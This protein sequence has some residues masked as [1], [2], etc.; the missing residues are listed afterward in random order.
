MQRIYFFNHCQDEACTGMPNGA[1]NYLYGYGFNGKSQTADLFRVAKN[2]TSIMNPSQHQWY[3][4]TNY[5]PSNVGDGTSWTPLGSQTGASVMWGYQ[6]PIY[7]ASIASYPI[8]F[9]V[10]FGRPSY[11]CANNSCSYVMSPYG[12]SAGLAT[13][14]A[15][16]GPFSLSYIPQHDFWHLLPWTAKTIDSNPYHT[17]VISTWDQYT[18]GQSQIVAAVSNSNPAT[19]TVPTL[20]TAPSGQVIALTVTGATGCWA[21]A[22]INA[23]FSMTALST[24]G[25][26]SV[27]GVNTSSCTGSA[28]GA[29][30]A[31]GRAYGASEFWQSVDLTIAPT[32]SG[33]ALLGRSGV[34]FTMAPAENALPR[35]GVQ[36]YFDFWDNV[37]GAPISGPVSAID[38]SHNPPIAALRPCYSDGPYGGCGFYGATYGG[39]WT[40]TGMT[41]ISHYSQSMPM[42]DLTAVQNQF[43]VSALSGDVSWT[44]SGVTS[45]SDVTKRWDMLSLGSGV[46][47]VG[48]SYGLG[49]ASGSFCVN[50]GA[51]SGAVGVCTPGDLISNNAP[52]AWVV[53]KTAGGPISGGGNVR[54]YLNG[55]EVSSYTPW[56]WA[57]PP[58]SANIGSGPLMLAGGYVATNYLTLTFSALGIWSQAFSATQVADMHRA[59]KALMAR[60]GVTLPGKD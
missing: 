42:T 37:G 39:G 53:T 41:V 2:I 15:P 51:S 16:W 4:Q 1:D 52:V 34:P 22:G 28:T 40:A 18:W 11:L 12:G 26:F 25:T 60:R 31:V 54:I 49:G 45:L 9:G 55:A 43:T 56:T 33:P 44:I 47:T 48:M 8:N 32:R 59:T 50:W 23:G 36:F 24:P 13:A 6:D 20:S 5:C 57:T 58:S 38:I 21:T 19:I 29:I 10:L 46:G 30:T 27:P 14:P 7:S 3:S 17:Q 35:R